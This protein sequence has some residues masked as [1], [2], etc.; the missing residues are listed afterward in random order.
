MSFNWLFVDM[1]FLE[2][3]SQDHGCS[4]V[5]DVLNSIA[6]SWLAFRNTIPI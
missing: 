6:T 5:M 2:D 3:K 1:G 4:S